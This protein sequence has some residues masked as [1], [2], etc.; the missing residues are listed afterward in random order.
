ME[1]NE[2]PFAEFEADIHTPAAEQPKARL[3]LQHYTPY[4]LLFG[5][6]LT[7]LAFL[8][9]VMGIAVPPAVMALG[10]TLVA[11]SRPIRPFLVFEALVLLGVYLNVYDMPGKDLALI[12]LLFVFPFIWTI[13]AYIHR[14]LPR[15]LVI[16]VGFFLWLII[17]ASL[18][19]ALILPG[20]SIMNIVTQGYILIPL[21]AVFVYLWKI[22]KAPYGLALV[23]YWLSAI[24][25]TVPFGFSNDYEKYFALS[26]ISLFFFGIVNIGLYIK[27]QSNLGHRLIASLLA[28]LTW[29]SFSAWVIIWPVNVLSLYGFITFC[30]CATA[31]LVYEYGFNPV[32][33][34]PLQRLAFLHLLAVIILPF[35]NLSNHT[36]RYALYCLNTQENPSVRQPYSPFVQALPSLVT[37]AD[38]K[39]KGQ[40]I[41]DE[42]EEHRLEEEYEQE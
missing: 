39:P 1:A 37:V 4:A 5:A 13:R 8:L 40:S 25:M 6:V 33:Y 23:V 19:R 27:L 30:L 3:L 42:A 18:F 11:V 15:W 20:A 28:V 10:L 24:L 7:L 34:R 36:F 29:L 17:M 21:I 14:L 22:K 38:P 2:S 32:Q 16:L 12:V 35:M 41:S 31:W 9:P 26:F